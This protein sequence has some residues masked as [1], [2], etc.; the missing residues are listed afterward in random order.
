MG[1][2]V[3]LTG[4][5]SAAPDRKAVVDGV[6]KQTFKISL[7]EWSLH[8]ALFGRKG[9][10]LDNLD[11]PKYAK[12]KYGIEA[13]EYVNQF[14]KD[15]ADDEKYLADLNRRCA[16]LGV[17]QVLIMI[18]GEGD[19]G[20]PDDAKRTKSVENHKRWCAAHAAAVT[21][22]RQEQGTP[23]NTTQVRGVIASAKALKG[24]VRA[25]RRKSRR[26]VVERRMA[27]QRHQAATRRTLAPS[28]ISATRIHDRC[29]GV[30]EL[31]PPAEGVAASLTNS[32]TQ[33]TKQNRL[34]AD[35]E[36]RARR[37]L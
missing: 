24:T 29:K 25:C 9:D 20:D 30:A 36:D 33:A 17:K 31:M 10:K 2:G 6:A 37:R 8:N 34:S 22:P 12:E 27:C 35:D 26:T 16:D 23:K 32:T 28:P 3:T 19:L 5:A 4:A 1:A 21:D 13:I 7:A 18:D 11:F 15:K 14:F